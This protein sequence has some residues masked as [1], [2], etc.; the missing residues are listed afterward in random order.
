MALGG[1]VERIPII[2][3][4]VHTVLTA[5]DADILGR[6]PKQWSDYIQTIGFRAMLF[7]G[8]RPR[9][10]PHAARSDSWSPE[11]AMPGEDPD[12]ARM[13]LLDR[14]DECAAVLND[15][16]VFMCSGG[17]RYPDEMAPYLVSA[18]NDRRAE[19]WL[20]HDPRWY[21]SINVAYEIPGA[22]EKEIERL[23]ESELGDRWVQV[24]LAPDNEKP[25]GHQKYW[26]M[27][28]VCEHYGLPVSFHVAG[29]RASTGTGTPNS[30]LA[31][32]TEFACYN[33]PIVPSM[34]F[35]GV[36]ERFPKLKVGLIE[37]A[38][39]WAMAYAWRLD[40]AYDMLHTE[41]PH[42]TR[43]PSEYMAEHFWYTTQPSEEPEWPAAIED[44][45]AQLVSTLGHRLMYA[46]DYPHWD[47]DEPTVGVPDSLPM[48]TRRRVLGQTASEFYGI[49]LV[50][51]TGLVV[52][53]ATA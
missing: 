29:G 28:E 2:D 52:D 27:Y 53:L 22:A 44:V 47:F 5:F 1:E 45:V 4:D 3:S 20:A 25:P 15:I 38:W 11:G 7:G 39:S 9:Q 48:D 46:S 23:K 41:V 51:G 32:H 34:I 43:K 33:F 10:R 26:G 30:Y 24:L 36:F 6:L 17:R 37:L 21:A 35:E 40:H 31:E 49:P 14:Y 12:F 19:K 50:Q 16:I 42:L 18:F 13:Q 8:E